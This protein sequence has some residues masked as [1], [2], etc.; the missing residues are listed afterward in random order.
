[1]DQTQ[2]VVALAPVVADTLVAVDDQGGDA[3]HLEAGGGDE[4]GVAGADDENGRL[5]LRVGQLLLVAA[6]LGPVL[7][8]RVGAVGHAVGP[9]LEH[10]LRIAVE[11]LERRV[12]GVGLPG[13]AAAAVLQQLD[14]AVAGANGG[15]DGDE[16]E[17]GGQL[18]LK[19][20]GGHK[21]GGG[22]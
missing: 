18:A 16:G 8:G 2:L 14:H 3:Q 9:V 17:D 21:A 7:A 5:Q 6:L 19:V 15:G 22:V 20:Q 1:M 12:N 10:A 4:A 13:A 11:R